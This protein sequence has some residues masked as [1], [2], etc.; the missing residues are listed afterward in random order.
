MSTG[1]KMLLG[2]G[3]ALGASYFAVKKV[4]AYFFPPSLK[5][6]IAIGAFAF[7]LF[8]VRNCS[9][10]NQGISNAYHGITKSI[11][12]RVDRTNQLSSLESK[13]EELRIQNTLLEDKNLE[14]SLLLKD[15]K[16]YINKLE[17]EHFNYQYTKKKGP[18]NLLK[19][20]PSKGAFADYLLHKEAY[21]SL[22]YK[23]NKSV[24][25]ENAKQH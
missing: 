17:L 8:C 22:I 23:I 16:K 25:G 21:S 2:T 9:T 5:K 3:F 11:E 19:D 6:Y 10:I 7:T 14:K 13:L 4:K 15:S 18:F 24:E 12:L 20:K 1:S